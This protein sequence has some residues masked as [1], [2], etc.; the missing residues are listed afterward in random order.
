MRVWLASYGTLEVM[1]LVDM[2]PRYGAVG[3]EPVHVQEFSDGWQRYY[4]S[5]LLEVEVAVL[6]IKV[7]LPYT[8]E[9][10]GGQHKVRHPKLREVLMA[11]K[12]VTTPAASAAASGPG[13]EDRA[14]FP[15]LLEYLAETKYPDG[16]AREPSA[17]I[18]VADVSGWRGCVSDKDNGRTLWKTATTVEGL[19]LALEEALAVDDPSLWRAASATKFKGKKRS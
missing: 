19:L 12:K 13:V 9:R 6:P 18:I 15:L 17:L 3:E 10:E 5:R 1:R 7:R 2:S 8:I 16:T 14:A 4:G 11:L